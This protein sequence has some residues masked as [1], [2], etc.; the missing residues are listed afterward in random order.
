MR[1]TVTLLL[2]LSVG[3][4][5]SGQMIQVQGNVS[6]PTHPVRYCLVTFA[7]QADTTRRSSALS[8]T[9][10]NYRISILTGVSNRPSPNPT[11]LEV[12]QNYPNPFSSGTAIAFQA[13]NEGEV[14]V[15]IYNILGQEVRSLTVADHTS[16]V[17]QVIWDGTDESRRKV[18]SGV[19]FY[20]METKLG[21]IVKKMVHLS[22]AGEL[23]RFA[24]N[25]RDFSLSN[26]RLAKSMGTSSRSYRVVIAKT[27]STRPP[28]ETREIP[29]VVIRGDTTLSFVVN[30]A[31]P[32]VGKL[33][34]VMMD[35]T[36][37]KR[38]LYTM[39]LDGTGL[40][41]VAIP[42]DTVYFPGHWGEYY[43]IGSY[44]PLSDPRWSP[45]GQKI[46][47]TLMWA[48]EGYVVM[49]MNADGTNKH[50]LWKVGQAAREPEWSPEGDRL[51]FRRIGALGFESG[52]GIVD[53]SGE[54]DRDFIIA[55]NTD[56]YVSGTDSVWFVGDYQW[57]PTGAT[58]Y[59][60]GSVNKRPSSAGIA[61]QTPEDEVFSFD[62]E[63]GTVLQRLTRN[64]I[65]EAGFRLSP[66]GQT[67]AFTRGA[68][69]FHLLSLKDGSHSIVYLS[70]AIDKSWNWSNDGRKVVY[71][72][73]ENPNVYHFHVYMLDL[74]KPNEFRQLTP[75]T[76]WQPD[77]YVPKN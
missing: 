58:I 59:G 74:D 70:G 29:D 34:F 37:G 32:E 69:E 54:N 48:F 66:Q 46:A 4:S 63:S 3:L 23:G 14:A 56:P 36:V 17:H 38:G 30:E 75:F 27:D 40:R 68:G 52:T 11:A 43:V 64:D 22:H 6:T 15:K 42:D 53:T 5:A 28:I 41:P 73:D 72:R 13:P 51:L 50:V 9:L 77:L 10:G 60:L 65:D 62:L 7:D 76:A 71:A 61:G 18:S 67:V 35:T 8:D 16:G 24:L 20:R 57:G 12:A 1:H 31:V 19:Y 55:G 21:S 26:T 25:L 33:V 45:D 47:C 44:F 39:N 49:L 2:L